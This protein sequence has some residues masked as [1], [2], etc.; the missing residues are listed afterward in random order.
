MHLSESHDQPHHAR[1]AKE[2][3]QAPPL[4]PRPTQRVPFAIQCL[5][6]P[7]WFAAEL[8]ALRREL[9]LW[10]ETACVH[11]CNSQSAL[12]A[13]TCVCVYLEHMYVCPCLTTRVL[14]MD[15]AG[16][17]PGSR[18]D[19]SGRLGT[20]MSSCVEHEHE[21]DHRG[22]KRGGEEDGLPDDAPSG[23]DDEPNQQP[24]NPLSSASYPRQRPACRPCQKSKVYCSRNTPCSRYV[25]RGR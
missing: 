3:F 2:L 21:H 17:S 5:A 14:C 9:L 16:D 8:S 23:D 11:W 7:R 22:S 20:A 15:N 18:R 19:A 25:I 24:P 12:E 6:L 10:A 1:S 13:L 4:A